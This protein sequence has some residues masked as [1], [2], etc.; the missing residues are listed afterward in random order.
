MDR[1]LLALLHRLHSDFSERSVHSLTHTLL[2]PADGLQVGSD[3][4]QIRVPERR[5]DCADINTSEQ[6]HT[7]EGGGEIVKVEANNEAA[8]ASLTRL[9]SAP[10]L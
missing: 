7:R 4:F 2:L 6:V 10:P 3:R 1:G 9:I 5:L 8:G